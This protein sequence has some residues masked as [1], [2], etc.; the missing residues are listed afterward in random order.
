MKQIRKTPAKATAIVET[1][2]STGETIV[3][4][5]SPVRKGE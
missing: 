5:F 4:T 3:M 1:V 2:K